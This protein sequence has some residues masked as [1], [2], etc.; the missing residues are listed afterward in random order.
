MALGPRFGPAT[1]PETQRDVVGLV[2]LEL[3]LVGGVRLGNVDHE[4]RR[5]LADV[6]VPVTKSAS[7]APEWRSSEAA[8]RQDQWP[9]ADEA[10][11]GLLTAAIEPR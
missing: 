11:K 1:I 7:L 8:E 2:R 3:P 9:I 4:E 6:V 10:I 5:A